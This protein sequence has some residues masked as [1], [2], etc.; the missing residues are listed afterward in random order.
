MDGFLN[1]G[2]F[3]IAFYLILLYAGWPDR[4]KTRTPRDI[5][6]ATREKRVA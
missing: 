4:R 2:L 5:E 1:L 3:L 6:A